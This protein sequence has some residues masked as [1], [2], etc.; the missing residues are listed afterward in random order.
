MT[1]KNL[2]TV[3]QRAISDAAFR[4]LLQSNPEAALRGFKL[5][6][7]EVAALRSGDAGKLMSLGIDQRM[8]KTFTVGG[9]ATLNAASRSVTGTE[10]GLGGAAL[11]DQGVARLSNAEI[12]P[13]S[14]G[15]PIR[16][17][18]DANAS[19]DALEDQSI[20]NAQSRFTSDANTARDALE[21]QS[22][23]NAQ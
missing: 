17:A 11:T 8:S 22:I 14:I 2:Q 19:R 12:D 23:A 3:I 7:D 9:E 6:S 20:A 13:G 21:N 15:D 5:T 4:R 10:L 1:S 18:D 16:T